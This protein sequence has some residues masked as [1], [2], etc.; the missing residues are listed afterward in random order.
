MSNDYLWE[1]CNEIMKAIKHDKV[2]VNTI[3][4]DSNVVCIPNEGICDP[5]ITHRKITIDVEI[6]GKLP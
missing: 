1:V 3:T 5:Y 6:P 4:V 2:R